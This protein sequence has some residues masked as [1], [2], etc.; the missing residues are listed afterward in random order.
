[1]AYL[2]TPWI[3]FFPL[4][5]PSSRR[6]RP[7][8]TSSVFKWNSRE[9]D[10]RSLPALQLTF[11]WVLGSFFSW[12]S[13]PFF[14]TEGKTD[15]RARIR[16]IN[17]DKNKYNTPKYRFVVRFVSLK[18]AVWFVCCFQLDTSRCG[19]CF[20]VNKMWSDQQ[21][22]HCPDYFCQHCRGLGPR[23]CLLTRAA[24]VR[25]RSWPHQLCRRYLFF[26]QAIFMP[27][28]WLFLP[29][30]TASAPSD[31]LLMAAYCTGLLLARRVLKTLNMDE[32]YEGN[33]EVRFMGIF[34]C[35]TASSSSSSS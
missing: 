34:I 32:E 27:C 1:M 6:R 4:V 23:C 33:V 9:G 15:Y 10:V 20:L 24:E 13:L 19:K 28:L 16:L 11:F 5:R 12:D 2:L 8:H 21:G 25:A 30:S 26:W 7:G 31:G 18:Y 14:F 29:C 35:L 22:Y 3:I 17:Q